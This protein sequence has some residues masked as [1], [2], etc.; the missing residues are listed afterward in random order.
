M[1][2]QHLSDSKLIVSSITQEGQNKHFKAI[3]GLPL[4][5]SIYIIIHKNCVVLKVWQRVIFY[6]IRNIPPQ[7]VLNT[8]LCFDIVTTTAL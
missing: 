4:S 3:T 2:E 6:N 7:H 1:N 8:L 5:T